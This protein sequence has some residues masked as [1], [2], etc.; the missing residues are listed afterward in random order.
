VAYPSAPRSAS[1]GGGA[2]EVAVEGEVAVVTY[3][4]RE[5]GF[6]VVKVDVP[7]RPDRLTIVGLFPR[8]GVG[9]RVRARGRLEVDPN[10]GEQLRA[11]NVT[12][13][14]P[15]TLSG[16]EKYLGSGLIK[17][18][19]GVT[20]QRIVTKFG[21]DTL[22]VLEEQPQRLREVPGLG[23][24]RADA[25]VASWN[26]QRALRD[27]MVFLQAHGAS[28]H[29]AGR[30]FKRYG[31]KAVTIVSSNPYRLAI[32][33]WGIGFRTADRIA[34]ELGIA[35]SSP[36][37]M[38]AALLQGLRDATEAGHCYLVGEELIA[39]GA[40]LLATEGGDAAPDPT[41]ELLG[42]LEQA[43]GAVVASGHVV[44]EA[45]GSVMRVPAGG[46]LKR[47]SIYDAKMHETE[48]R[49][50]SR[51]AALAKMEGDM[52]PGFADAI[53]RF[54]RE[55]G[56]VLADEQRLAVERA[57][58]CPLLIVTGGPG[59]GK[60]TIVK[61]ILGV[62][63]RAGVVARLAAPTGRAA[64]RMSEATGRQATTL[65]RLLEFDPKTGA[66]KRDAKR[67]VD[68]G[69]IV[70]DESSM[71]DV[72][73]GDALT[74]AVA[75]DARLVLV[76]DVDQLPSV[77]PG[78]V[79]RD[80][81]ASNVVPCVRLVKIFRQAEKSLIVQNAHRI[82]AGEQP[83]VAEKGDPDA[84]FF[85]MDRRDPDDTRALLIDLVTRHIPRKFGLDP[86]RDI[87]VL[88]PMNRGPV[89]TVVLNEAL[90]AALNPN[91]PGLV[92]GKVTFRV[93][94]KVMQLRNDY[95]RAVFNGDVGIVA[96]IDEELATLVVRFDDG[97]AHESRDVPYDG[98]ALDELAL[99]YACTVHKSQGSEYPAVVIPLLT[100]HFVML[101]KN[102][103]YTAV[104]RGKRLVVLVADPRALRLA[105]ADAS[106]RRDGSQ[107]EHRQTKLTLRI[108][109]GSDSRGRESAAT[110]GRSDTSAEA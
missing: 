47:A 81:I 106:S 4:N 102:L 29:L 61:A 33:V 89:G 3:E 58:R 87:Q 23:R 66:F 31:P 18:I 27:V 83:I 38:Q 12:E 69:A 8:V 59:V 65:H 32:D 67:P 16:I 5:S 7:G 91:G 82:N 9:S 79:L 77:G 100:T 13:L 96:S 75:D 15:T 35:K 76:G 104:T 14:A 36:E 21:L 50:A 30:I 24:T 88:T 94:D 68:G 45:E 98:R 17:G 48:T 6:R 84:D 99:A 105:L 70:V 64:K 101:S 2:S 95:D 85:M 97:D 108:Q 11:T 10:H 51:F 93:G 63:E 60:T 28:V 62:F 74:Q 22:K 52:L 80:A 86:V 103:V 40:R 37:R 43:L 53:E 57:A 55:T 41:M 49:L 1:A 54:E 56:T 44:A 72:W 110:E 34:S 39:R 25:L 19:G 73:M 92:R 26:E 71:V 107:S 78:S 90:Q 46:G 109:H 20:A 42:M